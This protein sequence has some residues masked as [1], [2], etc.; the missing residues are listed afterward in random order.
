[1]ETNTNRHQQSL[2]HYY[3]PNSATLKRLSGFYAVFSDPARI[4]ILTALSIAELC[5]SDIARFC[6]MQQSTV[7]HQLQLLRQHNLVTTRRDGKV[8]YYSISSPYVAKTLDVG[9]D[10]LSAKSR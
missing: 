4:K 1:M 5:V 6:C 10:Y 8:I 2:M 3:L 9:T 7:S